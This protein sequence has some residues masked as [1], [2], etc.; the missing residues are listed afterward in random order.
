MAYAPTRD[1]ESRSLRDVLDQFVEKRS[2]L[3]Q[4]HPEITPFGLRGGRVVTVL[5]DGTPDTLDSFDRFR[6][7]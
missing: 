2:A 3:S 6:P 1:A 5:G 4:Q 7:R